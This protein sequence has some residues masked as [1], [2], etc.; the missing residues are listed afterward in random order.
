MTH[1]K[2]Y[3]SKDT[4]IIRSAAHFDV[5]ASC[6]AIFMKG[7]GKKKINEFLFEKVCL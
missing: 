3:H 7:I 4:G 6:F 5:L 1:P 2:F